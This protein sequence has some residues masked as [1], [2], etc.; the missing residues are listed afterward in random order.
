MINLYHCTSTVIKSE[1]R[2]TFVLVL[3][4]YPFMASVSNSLG[5]TYGNRPF[6]VPHLP[7]DIGKVFT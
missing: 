5:V 7:A 1:Y 2:I 6:P 4:S 3:R